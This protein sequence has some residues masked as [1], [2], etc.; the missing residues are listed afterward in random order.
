MSSIVSSDDVFF[1]VQGALLK[2]SVLDF[3][4]CLWPFKFCDSAVDECGGALSYKLFMICS[5]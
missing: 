1:G 5:R 4:P 2:S 3:V